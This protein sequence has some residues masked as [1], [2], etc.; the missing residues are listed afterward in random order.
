MKC[1]EE[2]EQKK[3]RKYQKEI[4]EKNIEKRRKNEDKI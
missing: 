2:Y 3:G 1:K 4:E